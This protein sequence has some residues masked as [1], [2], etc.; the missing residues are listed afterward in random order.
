MLEARI[1]TSSQL[2]ATNKLTPKINGFRDF[3]NLRQDKWLRKA[4]ASF[5]FSDGTP[6][7]QAIS[8]SN[9]AVW[10]AQLSIQG[11][12]RE[13]STQWILWL[14]HQACSATGPRQRPPPFYLR[15]RHDVSM[16]REAKK[17]LSGQGLPK[18]RD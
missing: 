12:G 1:G 17:L 16:T 5:A 13:S 14:G 15:S 10:N 18:S 8:Q 3:G 2:D 9:H 6:E 4:V 11:F 7:K